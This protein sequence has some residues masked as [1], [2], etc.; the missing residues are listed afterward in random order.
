MLVLTRYIGEVI[1]IGP[2]NGEGEQRTIYL[3]ATG[4]RNGDVK[5][6]IQALKDIKILPEEVADR[7]ARAA[8]GRFGSDVVS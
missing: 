5:L 8:T 1:T 6:G 3:A 2:A 7:D 4:I